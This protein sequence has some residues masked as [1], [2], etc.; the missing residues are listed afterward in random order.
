[1]LTIFSSSSSCCPCTLYLILYDLYPHTII[2][3]PSSPARAAAVRRRS[4]RSGGQTAPRPRHPKQ[5]AQRALYF[6]SY[7][8][9][10]YYILYIRVRV[11]LSRQR[12]ARVSGARAV[13][14]KAASVQYKVYS[15][16]YTTQGWRQRD[17]RVVAALRERLHLLLLR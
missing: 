6:I 12:S 3:I 5:T 7:H 15:I 11:I 16:R 4:F 9:V 2:L 17:A 10:S 13:G 8:T 14:Y 1:M